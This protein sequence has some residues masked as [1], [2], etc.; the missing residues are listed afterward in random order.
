MSKTVIKTTMLFMPDNVDPDEWNKQSEEE[1]VQK[2]E[3]FPGRVILEAPE[4]F[5]ITEYYELAKEPFPACRIITKTNATRIAMSLSE[6]DSLLKKE[7]FIFIS[8]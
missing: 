4:E 2:S 1:K 6:L 8:C 7:G 5:Q 3:A